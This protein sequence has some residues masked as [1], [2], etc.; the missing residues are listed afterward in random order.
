MDKA[1]R[2]ERVM[3]DVVET[4]KAELAHTDDDS[5][6]E[7]A[8]LDLL[9]TIGAALPA[10]RRAMH[11]SLFASERAARLGF[12]SKPPRRTIPEIR[13]AQR[14]EPA[15]APGAARDCR[16]STVHCNRNCSLLVIGNEA[17]DHLK[18]L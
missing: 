16:N 10:L 8:Y 11:F 1:G 12:A 2:Y 4:L 15:T 9:K 14:G 7:R 18:R 17:V 3:D 13:P 6:E 5:V